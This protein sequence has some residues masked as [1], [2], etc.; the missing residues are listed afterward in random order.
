MHIYPSRK[1][2]RILYGIITLLIF[3]IIIGSIIG[4]SRKNSETPA[5]SIPKTHHTYTPQKEYALYG[6]F[7]QLRAS[8]V[9]KPA[10]T[11]VLTPFLEYSAHDTALQE[12]LVT[13]KDILKKTM[14]EWFSIQSAYRLSSEAPDYIKMG[15]IQAIN[16]KLLLGKIRNVYFEDFVILY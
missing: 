1:L 10:I 15:L 4:F 2:Y 5:V 3:I 13:K 12:E 11:I 7:G 9:D 16:E 8:T 14:L 6:D